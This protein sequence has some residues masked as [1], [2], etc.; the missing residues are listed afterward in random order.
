MLTSGADV[1]RRPAPPRR[2]SGKA[3]LTTFF[4]RLLRHLLRLRVA[5]VQSEHLLARLR[6]RLLRA[7]PEQHLRRHG[8]STRPHDERRRG[9]N[10]GLRETEQRSDDDELEDAHDGDIWTA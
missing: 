4:Y 7:E 9:R 2:P 1:L 6:G 8:I 5:L 3:F 10:E